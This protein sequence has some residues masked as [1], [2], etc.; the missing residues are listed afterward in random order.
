ML[1]EVLTAVVT[2]FG[3][4]GTVDFARFRELAEHLVESG[5]DGLVVAGTTG[6][7]PNLTDDERVELFRV[8]VDALRGRGTVVAGTGTYS[9]AH[10][11]HLTREAHD[12]SV[13]G[14]L[15]VT[16]YY[17]KPPPRGIVE[18][19][20]AI[21]DV[22]DRPIIVYNIPSRVVLNLEPETIVQLAQ[23]P[24]VRA[25]K[26]ANDD[27]AQAR[28]IVAET[29][30]DL[31]A[32]DDNLV[33]PFLELGGVG[34]V[35]VHTHVVGPRVKAMISAFR[36]GDAETARQIDQELEPVYELLKVQTNPIAI[37]AALNLL[38][39]DVGGLRL[40]LVE[41][42]E[43]EVARVRDCLE[44]LGLLTPVAV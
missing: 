32:G 35:C 15:V 8:A 36:Q 27:L 28:R 43:R 44:R 39:H 42:D 29:E 30:L 5:S 31:Y 21:A 26:Q 11:V 4:D 33:F 20:R 24:T 40:P 7:S 9:T 12:L 23:I 25:V 16:P 13:D 22:S 19:F 10:S 37:K 18:H 1:G 14:L 6:E 41:A 34:G 3:R 17:N 2:P 38:G